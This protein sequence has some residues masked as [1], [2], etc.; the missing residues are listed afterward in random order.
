MK[1]INNIT[2]QI[3]CPFFLEYQEK[4]KILS[5]SIYE[6][7]I[8]SKKVNNA[9]ELLDI[10]NILSSCHKYDEEKE[11][12]QRCHFI[13]NLRKELARIIIEASEIQEIQEIQD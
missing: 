5:K 10:I 9:Q 11:D 2:Y 6:P 13:L 12:C 7:K 1:K 4:I 3:D 8:I